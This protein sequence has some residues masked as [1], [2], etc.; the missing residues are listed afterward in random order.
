MELRA[1]GEQ[2]AKDGHYSEAIDAFKAADRVERRASHAC[3]IALVYTRRELWPQAEL[4]LAQC[5]ARANASDALPEWVPQLTTLLAERLEHVDV[6]PIDI[7]VE[8]RDANA[9]I[10]VSSFAPDEVFAPRSIHLP[11]GRHTIRASAPGYRSAQQ[12]IEV[13][14]RTPLRVARRLDRG[15]DRDGSS[16]DRTLFVAGL[17]ALGGEAAAYTAMSVGWWKLH[18]GH[19]FHS[20]YETLYDTGRVASIGLWFVTGALFGT[21]YYLHRKHDWQVSAALLPEGGVLVG[22]SRH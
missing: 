11:P 13:V 4:W 9:A 18:S 16:L 12:D 21:A 8:P 3:L 10:T 5:Q 2:L 17:F 15:S 22:I 14:G 1:R 6:A 19:G 7:V 20:G